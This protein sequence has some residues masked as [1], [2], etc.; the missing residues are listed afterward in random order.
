MLW[1]RFRTGGAWCVNWNLSSKVISKESNK[2][3]GKKK[4]LKTMSLEM[5]IFLIDWLD[6]H[7]NG[8]FDRISN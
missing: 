1:I 6:Y 8:S 2:W 7:L 5:K 4:I 3:N